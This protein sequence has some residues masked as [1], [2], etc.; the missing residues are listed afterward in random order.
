MRP[1][2]TMI[3]DIPSVQPLAIHPERFPDAVTVQ[4]CPRTRNFESFLED[5]D[6]VYTAETPYDHSLFQIAEQRNI[7]TVLH[8]NPELL[9]HMNEPWLPKPSVFAC[10]STW[11]FDKIPQPRTLLPFPVATERFT[12]TDAAQAASFLHIVGRPAIHDRNG[13]EDLLRA[14][15][16]VRSHI[17]V[18]VCCQLSG[19]V[20]R[21]AASVHIPSNVK[22]TVRSRDTQNYWDNYSGQHVLVLPRRFGGLCLPMQE[23]LAAGMPVIMPNISPNN[24]RLPPQWLTSAEPN[25]MFH[26]KGQDI[27]LYS[28]PPSVLAAMIDKFATDDE[29]FRKAKNDALTIAKVFSWETLKPRYDETLGMST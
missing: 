10:P 16:H 13:T 3:V 19:Y 21:L 22:L 28:T 8:V 6:V 5:L 14:L 23:A 18:T 26:T 20:E 24:D 25:G 4:G 12:P 11:M 7:R 9:A 2:K 17:T 15:Q 29:F 27:T 1:A